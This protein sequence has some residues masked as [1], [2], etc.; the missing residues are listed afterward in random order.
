MK[1]IGDLSGILRGKETNNQAPAPLTLEKIDAS[2]WPVI[3]EIFE[4]AQ[5][6]LWE[7]HISED[8]LIGTRKFYEILGSAPGDFGDSLY[9]MADALVHRNHQAYFRAALMEALKTGSMDRFKF[10]I[11]GRDGQE[12]WVMLRG[13]VLPDGNTAVGTLADWTDAQNANLSLHEHLDFMQTLLDAIPN[14]VFYKDADG[15][16][17]FCNPAFNQM[18]GT[19]SGNILGKSVDDVASVELASV[20]R[21]KDKELFA[22][23]GI[24]AYEAKV[25]VQSGEV[26]NYHMH[27]AVCH[28]HQ[29]AVT[30]LVGVM[31]DITDYAATISRNRRLTLLK[32]AML[33]VSHAIICRIQK[34]CWSCCWIKPSARFPPPMPARC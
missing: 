31:T 11:V 27:K 22:S 13:R 26:R 32:E 30:G 3:E 9:A 16:Y 1:L 15:M 28:N 33:E 14:P 10:R 4:S 5:M 24:Q 2:I 18:I 23:G 34:I 29:G 20:Y 25:E 6:A 19:H 17:Q 12:R 7:W 21:E 8:R